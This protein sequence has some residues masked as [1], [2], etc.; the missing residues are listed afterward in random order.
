M[1]ESAMT[2]A[3]TLMA[4]EMHGYTSNFR[5]DQLKKLS[6]RLETGKD[7]R[8][9]ITKDFPLP[10]ALE[11]VFYPGFV[12]AHQGNSPRPILVDGSHQRDLLVA[13]LDVILIDVDGAMR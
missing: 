2:V 1:P 13:L 12:L 3:G 5:L 11:S 9:F 10:K 4:E 8:I 7:L 6:L